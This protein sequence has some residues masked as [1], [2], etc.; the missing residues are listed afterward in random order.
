MTFSLESLILTNKKNLFKNSNVLE[1]GISDHH[2]FIT[3]VLRNQL[4]KGNAKMKMRKDY[5]TFNTEFFKRDLRERLEN[6]TSYGYSCFQNIF[7]ALL[8]KNTPIK[9]RIM[10]FNNNLFMS[11]ALRKAIMHRSKLKK[12][13]K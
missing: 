7:I 10:R 5:K 12:H 4:I 13:N 9:K 8:N 2:S 11:K 3:T 1:I 6:H